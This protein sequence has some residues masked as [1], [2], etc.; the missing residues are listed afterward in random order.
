MELSTAISL[1]QPAVEKSDTPQKWME[2][3]SGKGLFTAALSHV[4]PVGSS[5][6]AVDKMSIE[7]DNYPFQANVEVEQVNLDF[8][9]AV[10]P[11]GF[12]GVLMANSLHFVEDKKA[13]FR[14]LRRSMLGNSTLII[15]EYDTDEANRWVPFPLSFEA[16]KKEFQGDFQKINRIGHVK[17][18]F[19]KGGIYA[20]SLSF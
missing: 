16:F 5:I 15:L 8:I 1:I 12:D 11:R 20:M 14:S 18:V 7:L 6:L 4:V 17:S 2:L 10:M 3:G 9:K 13:F 19:Q